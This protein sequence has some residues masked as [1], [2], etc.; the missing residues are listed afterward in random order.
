MINS[1]QYEALCYIRIHPTSY[2][3]NVTEEIGV[4]IIESL[5]GLKFIRYNAKSI[6]TKSTGEWAG[7]E[8]DYDYA[9]YEVTQEGYSAI[10]KYKAQQRAEAREE[11]TIRIA[12]EANTKSDAA[13]RT[14]RQANI[15]SAIAGIIAILTLLAQIFDW[16]LPPNTEQSYPQSQQSEYQGNN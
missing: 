11:E 12:K 14:S 9:T 8:L 15:I 13:N 10:E 4:D 7:L 1:K 6:K 2:A 16:K 5:C 3:K